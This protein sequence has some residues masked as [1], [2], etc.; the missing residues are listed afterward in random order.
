MQSAQP[1]S[2]LYGALAIVAVLIGVSHWDLG[3]SRVIPPSQVTLPPSTAITLRLDQTLSS[4]R[5]APSQ[6]FHGKLAQPLMVESRV[7]LPAGTEFSGVVLQAVPA[8]KLA[9]GAMLRIDL[10]SFKFQGKEYEVQAPSLVHT[11]RGQETRT[12]KV[13]G[14]GAL[15]GTVVGAVVHGK[16]GALIGAIAGAGAGAVGA[17]ATNKTMDIVLPAESLVTFHLSG[18]ITVPT[19]PLTPACRFWLFS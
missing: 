16:Q 2:R 14:G 10:K 4:K 8:G 11:T 5:S 7:A 17:A 3:S 9:G 12:A 15:I 13:V 6:L 1:K 19:S 18:S